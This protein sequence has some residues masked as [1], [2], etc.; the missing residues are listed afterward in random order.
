MDNAWIENIRQIAMQAME[1]GRPCDVILGTVTS[2]A[3]LAV[4]IDQ[5]T[6]IAGNHLLVPRYLTDHEEQ[7]TIPGVGN[8][9]VT[10]KNVLKPGDQVILIQRRGAQQ[11]LVIDRY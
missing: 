8:V 3:P 9:S 2:A 10:V 7:M 1:A 4:Q 6:T 5:K 11:Y